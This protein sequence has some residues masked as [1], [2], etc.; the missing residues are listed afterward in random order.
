MKTFI[1]KETALLKAKILIFEN[2]KTETKN[3]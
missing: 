3:I 2:K 1:L